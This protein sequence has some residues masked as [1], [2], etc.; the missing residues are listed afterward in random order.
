M[1]ACKNTARRTLV[2]FTAK[3]PSSESLSKPKSCQPKNT[4]HTD[5]GETFFLFCLT[6]MKGVLLVYSFY[7]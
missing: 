3:I 6:E 4:N 2:C 5:T 7:C 1:A